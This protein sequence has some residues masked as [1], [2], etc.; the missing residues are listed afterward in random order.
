M[1]ENT[2]K[3]IQSELDRVGENKLKGKLSPDF[4][5]K[6]A[7]DSVKIYLHPTETMRICILQLTTGHEVYGVAQVLR[8]EN[9]NESLGKKVAY[10]NARDKIWSTMGSI[11]KALL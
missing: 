4:I 1:N 8:A 11:A 3:L 7:D 10:D 6:L 9:D 2:I 5:N